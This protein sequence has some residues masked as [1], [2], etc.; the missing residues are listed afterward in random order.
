[1]AYY[2]GE[3]LAKD[4]FSTI[5]GYITAV[6]PGD[7]VAQWKKESSLEADGV[8]T[9]K[10]TTGTER[11]VLVFREGTIGANF[12]V[13]TARDYTPGAINTAGAFDSL[14]TQ[15][16]NY[17]SS[18][19]DPN[20]KVKFDLSVTAD[21][22][23]LHVQGDKLVSTWQNT[24]VYLGIPVRYSLSD[25]KCVV[26]GASENSIVSAGLRVVEDAIAQVSQNYSWYYVG[27]PTNPSWGNTY[28][29]ETLHFGKINEGLRGEL[30]G[31]YG[32]HD[33]GLVDGDEIDING[34]RYLVIKRQSPGNNAFPRNTLLF[35]KS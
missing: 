8:Y 11:I 29:V 18:S 9:S 1:M 4:L 19:Q 34:K 33:A 35:R 22:V 25:K 15:P 13:G 21:R 17:F 32:S 28:F 23:I 30:D 10:G 7:T 16:V 2:S 12:T 24:V 3:V 31:L 26:L 14:Q 5:L 6:Q 27:A 20:N